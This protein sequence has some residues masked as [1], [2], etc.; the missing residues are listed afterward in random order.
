MTPFIPIAGV[1][2][3]GVGGYYLYRWLTRSA[4]DDEAIADLP[5]VDEGEE[6]EEEIVVPK[7]PPKPSGK[8]PPNISGNAAGFNTSMFGSP[9]KVRQWM[10]NLGYPV[11]VNSDPVIKVPAVADFQRDYNRVSKTAQIRGRLGSLYHGKIITD[12]GTL[13]DDGTA[14]PN[15]LNAIEIA[16]EMTQRDSQ[17]WHDIVSEA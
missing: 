15:T 8:K 13:D 1:G 12:M 17:S 11:I 2:V 16:F 5:D 14:G 9:A 10:V 7:P 3:V 4:A 6:D